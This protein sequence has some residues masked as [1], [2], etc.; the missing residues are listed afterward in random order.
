MNKNLAH[1]TL[2][3]SLVWPMLPS[4]ADEPIAHLKHRPFQEAYKDEVPVSGRVV[5]GVSLTGSAV[6]TAMLALLPPQ[7]AAGS[8]VCVQVMS[9]DGR[10]W[11]RNTY[12]LPDG[13]ST[14]EV[15]L[16]YPSQHQEFL[17]ELQHEDLAV[18][19]SAGDCSDTDLGA[20]FLTS[21]GKQDTSPAQMKVFVNS[22]RADTYIAVKN[23]PSQSRPSHCR[24][25]EEGRR[26]GYDTICS[27]AISELGTL[28]GSLDIRIIRRHY[29]RMLP[30]TEFTIILP[31]LQ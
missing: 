26:T 5:V 8:S 2:T 24:T 16:E 21:A 9:R 7:S 17:R 1:L 3:V 28:P 13:I 23:H 6:S 11:S 31:Q 22:S 18:L 20:I 15:S 25:I 14:R 27:L 30:V 19:G 10:Y 29:E 12:E 4:L